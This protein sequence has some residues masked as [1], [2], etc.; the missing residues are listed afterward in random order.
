MTTSSCQKKLAIDFMSAKDTKGCVQTHT[1]AHTPV[2]SSTASPPQFACCPTPSISEAGS[3]ST[4]RGNRRSLQR[5]DFFARMLSHVVLF[6][7]LQFYFLRLL[8]LLWSR[9]Y[10]SLT[11]R[12]P[13]DVHHRH[14]APRPPVALQSADRTTVWNVVL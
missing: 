10:C 4:G 8:S 12:F 14:N 7:T 9:S 13:H 11:L 1:H 2:C 3:A 5:T 6:P